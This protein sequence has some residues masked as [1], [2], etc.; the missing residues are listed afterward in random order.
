M[1]DAVTVLRQEITN[2][3]QELA[4]RR[5][6]LAV[7]TGS[8]A[9]VK[10]STTA[11]PTSSPKPPA[12]PP[13]GERILTYLTTNKG[14][15]FAPTQVADALAKT[16]KSVKRENVQRRLGELFKRKRVKRENGNY[17]VA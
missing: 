5:Q 2:L 17:G 14:K 15:L 16:D 13:L 7:L 12:G 4:K 9:P 8:A 1:A 6:A 10:R 3:E 11:Q